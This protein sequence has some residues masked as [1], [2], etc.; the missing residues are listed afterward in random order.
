VSS[1]DRPTWLLK[2][3]VRPLLYAVSETGNDGKSQGRV[4]SLRLDGGAGALAE[5]GSAPSGGGGPTHLALDARSHTLLVA[6]YGTGHVAT[7]GIGDGGT[8]SGPVSIAG[9]AG[10]GPSPR[11]KGPHAHG[12]T[13][14]PSGRYV[15][16]P[17]LGADRVFVY[18]FDAAT[19][20][21]APAATPFLQL[22]PGSGPRHLVFGPG[23]RTA[24]LLTEL[25]G[26]LRVLDWDAAAGTLAPVQALSIQ[27]P[28]YAG[29]AS[30]GELVVSGDG[31]MLYASNRGEHAIVAFAIEREMGRLSEAQRIA[32]GGTAPWHLALSPAGT[33]L[34]ASN[35]KSDAVDVFRVGHDGRLAA[36]RSRLDVP[37]PVNVL[38]AGACGR[39]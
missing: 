17:D 20:A 24:Y 34:L 9:N 32:S 28:N 26:E 38:F 39:P 31:T 30:A 13:L 11:Q 5:V 27:G 16:V 3:P 15:L 25:T 7:L 33:W 37:T 2:D 1:F 23:G 14:D 10:S 22:P 35:E 4:A 12:V 29:P 21:L 6:N 18:R 36:T 8:L 19:R